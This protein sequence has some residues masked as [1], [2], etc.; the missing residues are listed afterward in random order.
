MAMF[1][2]TTLL[3]IGENMT[4]R[5]IGISI[6]LNVAILALLKRCMNTEFAI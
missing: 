1:H 4:G 3:G 6:E 5:D 2:S